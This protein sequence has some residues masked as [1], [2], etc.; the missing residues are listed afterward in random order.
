MRKKSRVKKVFLLVL[1]FCLSM[2]ILTSAHAQTKTPTTKSIK[3]PQYGGT[4]RIAANADA[5]VTLGYPPQLLLGYSVRYV[6][7]CIETLI[8]LNERGLPAPLLATDWKVSKDLKSIT[9]TLRKGVKFHDGTPWNAEA[10]K[11]NLDK[12]RAGRTALFLNA[13]SSVD[14]VDEYTIRLNLSKW[15]N[16]AISQLSTQGGQMISPTAYKTYGEEWCLTHPVGTGPFKF[17]SW[18]R[19][20]KQVYERFD[21]YWQKGKPYLDRIEWHIIADPVTRMM[22]FKRGEVDAVIALDSKMAKELE[23]ERSYKIGK[24]IEQIIGL[25]GDSKNPGSKFADLRVRKAIEYAL[26][27]KAICDTVGAGYWIPI[28]QPARPGSWAENP[29]VTG[30]RYNPKK[31]KEL[32]IE[33]GYPKGFKTKLY[34]RS[35]TAFQDL[36]VAVQGY[37]KAVGINAEIELMDPGRYYQTVV[38]SGWKD[39]LVF[40][41]YSFP[42]PDEV[43]LIN[44]I[45][46]PGFIIYTSVGVPPEYQ[47]LIA[48]AVAAPDFESKKALTH[49][50]MKAEVDNCVVSNLYFEQSAAA[51]NPKIHNHELYGAFGPYTWTPADAWIEK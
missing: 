34:T 10:A 35:L 26:D 29:S 37:L 51:F 3:G 40:S 31:A 14:V 39:G 7:P 28:W 38:D 49:R 42:V 41:E 2:F 44:K 32:L 21:G 36:A 25:C 16:I 24:G 43:W 30:Y 12:L 13:V 50:V 19:D 20:V 46:G 33:A 48:Q 6:R 5:G 8:E 17:V 11:W 23:A 18:E 4:L 27:K 22:A 9:F 45:H 15:Q 47:N 1:A